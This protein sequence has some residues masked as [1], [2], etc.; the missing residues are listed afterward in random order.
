MNCVEHFILQAHRVP[1]CE[2]I[3]R[4]RMHAVAKTVVFFNSI[5][6]SEHLEQHQAIS[7][8]RDC[9]IVSRASQKRQTILNSDERHTSINAL[10]IRIYFKEQEKI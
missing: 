10:L 1:W 8:H 7:H 5:N 9:V 6:T 4:S 3:A 2:R